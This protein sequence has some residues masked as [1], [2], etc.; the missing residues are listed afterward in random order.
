MT[1]FKEIIRRLGHPHA[2]TLG[3]GATEE[4]ILAA[5]QALGVQLKGHYR[6]FLMTFGWGGVDAFEVFGLG[7]GVPSFL[8]LVRITHSERSQ[9]R[10]PLPHTLIPV[11]S[12]GAGNHYCLDTDARGEPPVVFWNHELDET[13]IPE[14]EAESFGAWIAAQ[15]GIE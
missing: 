4:E 8:D 13:Q 5:E 3:Q 15:V 7:A 14:A 11:A 12:D 9:M 1:D 10:P 2:S 6:E